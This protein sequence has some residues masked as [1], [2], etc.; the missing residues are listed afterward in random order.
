MDITLP[1]AL[2]PIVQQAHRGRRIRERRGISP[3]SDPRR[4]RASPGVAETDGSGAGGDRVD[5]PAAPEVTRLRATDCGRRGVLGELEAK[6]PRA[7]GRWI[8]DI[9]VLPD[10]DRDLFEQAAYY[11]W[12]GSPET[13]DRWVDQVQATFRF[14][15]QN[16]GIGTPWPTRRHRRLAG[17]RTWPVDGFDQF[18]IF[19][20]RVERGIEILRVLSGTRDLGRLL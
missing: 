9:I 10:A 12:Q 5:R 3:R 15:A 13:A 18:I 8:S 4:R 6:S 2:V 11:H 7:E 1:E 16:P 20:R 17:L 14:L 19:Y